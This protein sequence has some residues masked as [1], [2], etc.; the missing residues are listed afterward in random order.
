MTLS[1]SVSLF[2]ATMLPLILWCVV[3]SCMVV[4]AL[5][6]VLIR[7]LLCSWGAS[8]LKQQCVC[9]SEKEK[10]CCPVVWSVC[11]PVGPEFHLLLVSS[12]QHELPKSRRAVSVSTQ[13]HVQMKNTTAHTAWEGQNYGGQLYTVPSWRIDLTVKQTHPSRILCYDPN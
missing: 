8:L 10:L 3:N 11:L 2:S 6:Q 5:N 1:L 12:P 9:E 7:A 13:A 4:G